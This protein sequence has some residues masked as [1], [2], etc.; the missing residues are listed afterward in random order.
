MKSILFVIPTMR[1]GGAEKAL[2]SLLKA[3]DPNRCNIDLLLFEAG[4]VLQSE[5]PD[6]V[7][8]TEADAVTRGMV[9]EMRYFLGDVIK[10]GAVGAAI[11]RIRIT[12][13]SKINAKLGKASVFSWGVIEKHMP[14][15]EK[16]YDVAFGF[17]E[18][19][20]DFYIID[21]VDADKK[22]GW[23]HTDMSKRV[24][25][26]QELELYKKF[27]ALATISELCKDTFIK[28]LPEI[29]DRISVVENIV[30]AEDIISKAKEPLDAQWDKNKTHIVTVGRLEYAKGIDVGVKVCKILKEHG[31]EICWHV[32]GD[33]SMRDEISQMI[34]ENGLDEHY[35]L[36]GL[37]ANPYPYINAAD[38]LVQPS[39]WEG[40]SVVLDEAKIL[41]K[42]IV[43]TAYPSVTDQIADGITGIITGM[44]PEE[45][46]DGIERVLADGKFRKELERNCANEENRSIKALNRFYDLVE[47]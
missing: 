40:K 4:G 30:L 25:P 12:L 27:D 45:I 21:K 7:N 32:Y 10:S 19:F 36:E 22:I 47:I 5:L 38:I 28:L 3:L 18:G 9:L 1:M 24:L 14:K 46:A 20:T 8:V 23:I 35:V 17:L 2:V 37:T 41:G 34:N 15:L 16:H 44:E 11:D 33:G 42:A 43:T 6:Y 29:E 39:R 13:N 31:I 26:V